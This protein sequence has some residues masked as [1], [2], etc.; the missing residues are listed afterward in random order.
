MNNKNLATSGFPNESRK[1]WAGGSPVSL[2]ARAVRPSSELSW[3]DAVIEKSRMN[4]AITETSTLSTMPLGAA[5]DAFFVSS[6]TLS[7]F[8]VNGLASY[9][10]SNGVIEWPPNVG[11]HHVAAE[12]AEIGLHRCVVRH[13]A[14]KGSV[15]M[16]LTERATSPG[17]RV[18][19][20]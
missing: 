1:I 17:F 6:A 12:A 8:V 7:T 14:G 13:V 18:N 4:P 20:W 16:A 5:T 10:S 3:M 2:A 11:S 15:G 19:R 9:L